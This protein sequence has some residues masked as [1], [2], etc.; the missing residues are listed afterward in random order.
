VL[1]HRK[2]VAHETL[3]RNPGELVGE[4]GVLLCEQLGSEAIAVVQRAIQ[5]E[6][7]GFDH[8]L[9]RAFARVHSSSSSAA[10]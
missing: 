7:N 10:P 6:Q 3:V 4:P 8:G 9:E 1:V 2:H 5:I